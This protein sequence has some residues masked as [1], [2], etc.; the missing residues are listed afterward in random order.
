MH[1]FNIIIGY[2]N[3]IIKG[4]YLAL[5]LFIAQLLYLILLQMLTP[6]ACLVFAA[7]CVVGGVRGVALVTGHNP[8]IYKGGNYT[9]RLKEYMQFP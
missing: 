1:W 4:I 7:L 3:T 9:L 6:T 8:C 5:Q 2:Y